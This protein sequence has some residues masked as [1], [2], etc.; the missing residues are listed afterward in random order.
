ML[1]TGSEADLQ[2][3][4]GVARRGLLACSHHGTSLTTLPHPC[5]QVFAVVF[6]EFHYMNDPD[7]G[8]V[9]EESVILSPPHILFVA[10]SATIANVD[11][12]CH[13]V[14]CM[15]PR[16]GVAC[17]GVAWRGLLG[18]RSACRQALGQSQPAYIISPHQSRRM[19]SSIHPG[20]GVD[21]VGAR[22]HQDGRLGLPPR[23][24]QVPLPRQRGHVRSVRPS[25]HTTHPCPR[26][27]ASITTALPFPFLFF[28]LTRYRLFDDD[29]A[30]P[31]APKG[32]VKLV[33]A[34][35]KGMMA[36]P[37]S[38]VPYL[39]THICPFVEV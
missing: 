29:Q 34:K 26:T 1:Y 8:T 13:V 25:A 35:P 15:R 30:G 19:K 2:E 24:P 22:A 23:A 10:L 14:S 31:G 20:G 16:R 32:L 12:V 38:K 6:D 11:Q 37:S 21:R 5:V 17:R 28:L 9:W 3:V 7:R 36:P 4:R 18:R 33:R 39:P 27:A